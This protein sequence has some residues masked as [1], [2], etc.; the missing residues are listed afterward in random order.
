VSIVTGT[1]PPED[2]PTLV[3]TV[4]GGTTDIRLFAITLAAAVTASLSSLDIT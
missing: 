3:A 4:T 1:L 2:T